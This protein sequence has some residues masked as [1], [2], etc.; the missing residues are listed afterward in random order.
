VKDIAVFV[1]PFGLVFAVSTLGRY[2][3][4]PRGQRH[5]ITN[6]KFIKTLNKS[7]CGSCAIVIDTCPGSPLRA[8]KA[9]LAPT[10]FSS[11]TRPMIQP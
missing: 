10:P 3:L 7:S 9:P 6:N 1:L 4:V 8:R 5:K 11:T 2:R